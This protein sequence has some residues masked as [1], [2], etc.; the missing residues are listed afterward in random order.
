MNSSICLFCRDAIGNQIDR[1]IIKES[2]K[3][4]GKSK[5]WFLKMIVILRKSVFIKMKYIIKFAVY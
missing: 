5:I 4:G 3:S 2:L 1:Q